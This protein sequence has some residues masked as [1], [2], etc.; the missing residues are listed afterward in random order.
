ML[1]VSARVRPHLVGATPLA[2][3]MFTGTA[4]AALAAAHVAPGPAGICLAAAATLLLTASV[5]RSSMT[6]SA[7]FGAL[8]IVTAGTA[9]VTSA[10]SDNPVWLQ[11]TLAVSGL[12]WLAMGWRRWHPAWL[13][14]GVAGLAAAL[15][16]FLGDAGVVVV[17][18]YTLPLATLRANVANPWR[19]N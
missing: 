2:S 8:S 4:V 18:A 3:L 12:S 16:Q 15:F 13:V 14:P 5:V 19:A 9:I 1:G 17:E 6:E 10:A 11:C 7:A